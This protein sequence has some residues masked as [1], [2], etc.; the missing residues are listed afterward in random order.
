MGL[1]SFL[2][3]F[4][5]LFHSGIAVNAFLFLTRRQMWR[6]LGTTAINFENLGRALIRG[7][8]CYGGQI[9]DSGSN[10]AFVMAF[11]L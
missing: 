7:N 8:P 4:L 3:L 5:E 1:S 11:Q 2:Y 6:G 10:L 9:D